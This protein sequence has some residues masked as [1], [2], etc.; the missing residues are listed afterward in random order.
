MGKALFFIIVV[1]LCIALIVILLACF[2][3]KA[4]MRLDNLRVYVSVS[5]LFIRIKREYVIKTDKKEFL[6]IYQIKNGN[7]K[8]IASLKSILLKNHKGEATDISIIDA[9]RIIFQNR[10][11]KKKNVFS[12]LNKKS[13]F[14][15]QLQVSLG[16]GDAY[17]TALL[18]GWL[19]AIGG[20]FCAVYSQNKKL[21][22]F[23]VKPEFNRL[24]FS[25]QSD[26]IITIT[27][28]NIILGYFIYKIK[29]RGK[30]HASD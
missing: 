8:K 20:S 28:A 11:P 15:V 27:P 14:D 29:T 12:Y 6:V 17:Y 26:C 13:S 21:F 25:L 5:Y 9:A 23:S 24:S 19:A 2:H 22:R 16:V 18:C 4:V 7:E 10:E 3:I 1:L 30:K